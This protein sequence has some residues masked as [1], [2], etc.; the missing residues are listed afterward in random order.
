MI[1]CAITCLRQTN[2]FQNANLGFSNE[3]I[4]QI[5]TPGNFE[6]EYTL[7]ETF[8]EELLK[9]SREILGVS[10]SAGSPG[11]F[12]PSWSVDIEGQEQT[13]DFFLVDYEY[14]DVMGIELADG[15]TFPEMEL[16]KFDTSSQ[17]RINVIVNES[18][19]RAFGI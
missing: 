8:R 6:Q 11:A 5:E 17:A 15:K 2:Y 4:V 13:L 1:L 7:R 10:F 14:V 18:F 16:T 19:V 3:E 9:S 12:I